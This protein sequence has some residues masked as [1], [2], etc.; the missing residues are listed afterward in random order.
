MNRLRGAVGAAA[1]AALCA[2]YGWAFL[3]AES[4]RA[5]ALLV[6]AGVAAGAVATR[7]RLLDKLPRVPERLTQ[8]FALLAVVGLCLALRE[9]DFSLL[10]V[11]RVLI[12]V[13]ACLGLHIQL[14]YAG[15][16]N[17]AGASFFGVGGDTAAVLTRSTGV[18]PL[19]L[20]LARGALAPLVGTLI[21]AP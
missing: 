6:L 16:L 18:P 5:L 12:V 17:F 3:R 13:L 19:P 11:A 7:T 14:G 2:L 9:D 10:L 8:S 1:I 21:V 4:Q 20:L 15:V